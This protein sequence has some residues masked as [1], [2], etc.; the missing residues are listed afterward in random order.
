LYVGKAFIHGEGKNLITPTNQQE[1]KALRVMQRDEHVLRR[2]LLQGNV[3]GEWKR[4][5]VDGGRV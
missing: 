5:H 4:R 2:E 1:P 3:D